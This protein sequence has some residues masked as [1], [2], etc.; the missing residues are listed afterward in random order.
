MPLI[1][2]LCKEYMNKFATKN[3]NLVTAKQPSNITSQ[4]KRT[5]D[6]MRSIHRLQCKCSF[7][8]NL[9]NTK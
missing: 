6:W 3:V 4:N 8:D 7:V 2:L 9:L 1:T 5:N